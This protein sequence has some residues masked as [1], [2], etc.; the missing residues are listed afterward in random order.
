MKITYGRKNPKTGR[1]VF[2]V[3]HKFA[4]GWSED[5]RCSMVMRRV[6]KDYPDAGEFEIYKKIEGGE[7]CGGRFY[8]T[9]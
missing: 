8:E 6:I 4:P 2:N 9:N 3:N 1:I 5:D 7:I